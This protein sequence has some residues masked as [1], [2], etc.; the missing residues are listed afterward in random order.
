MTE[1]VPR[2]PAAGQ[3]PDHQAPMA[4]PASFD[5]LPLGPET[6][7]AL[8]AEGIET[9]TPFQA[10]AIPVIARGND[11]LGRAGPGSG[12]MVAYA[13]P[14]SERLEAGAGSPSCL[15]LCTG[16][17][18]ATE[19]ARSLAGLCEA[20]GARAAALTHR[21][22]L[23]ERA[24]FLVVPA[25]RFPAVYDG[26]V[27]L[28]HLRAVVFHDGDGVVASV[29]AD[30][31]EAFLGGLPGDCQRIVCGLPFGPALHSLAKRF[32]RR[33]VS[34]P[35]GPRPG[36]TVGRDAGSRKHPTRGRRRHAA[37]GDQARTLQVVVTAGDRAEAALDQ[38]AELLQDPVRHVLVFTTSADHAADLGDFLATHGYQPG[39]PGDESVPVWISPGEDAA[40]RAALDAATDPAA[41]ATLSALVPPGAEVATI[42][43]GAG[44]PARVLAEIRELTHL[45][46]LAAEAGFTLKRLRPARPQR[47]SATLDQLADDLHGAARAP[48]IAPYYLLVESL[49]DRFSAAEMAAAAL[50]LLD[51]KTPKKDAAA[52]GAGSAAAPESWVRLFVSAGQRDEVGPRELLGALTNQSGVPGNRV[53]RIDVRESHSL[54]EVREGDAKKVIS[55]LNGTTLAGRSLRVD[56]DRAK[57]RRPAGGGRPPGRDRRPV[58]PPFRPGGAGTSGKGGSRPRRRDRS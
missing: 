58:R 30:H 3:A 19:L 55:A 29:A 43:H 24:D 5:E 57:D 42:R 53:G 15:V 56:Y 16:Q 17:R 38:T 1:A 12:T 23:P 11:L 48:E 2:A 27:A 13:A 47:V 41:I 49:L 37:T 31:L 18:Q 32:T 28:K 54:I 22:N 34:V 39:P 36:T 35:P 52:V 50:L 44:G 10:A 20:A 46:G 25:D 9:P 7:A 8:A 45:K 26:T 14:L 33:A 21:W 51:R 6:V 40:G 4:D